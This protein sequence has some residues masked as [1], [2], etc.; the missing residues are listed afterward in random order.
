[1]VNRYFKSIVNSNSQ[2]DGQ[3]EYAYCI[4]NTH[5]YKLLKLYY[6]QMTFKYNKNEDAQIT[7]LKKQK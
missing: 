2:L 4:L 7:K 1:M 6:F 3:T 5:D